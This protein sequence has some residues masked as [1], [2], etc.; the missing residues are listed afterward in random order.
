MPSFYTK[1]R[2]TAG[3]ISPP[4]KHKKLGIYQAARRI[5]YAHKH[6]VKQLTGRHNYTATRSVKHPYCFRRHIYAP[7]SVFFGCL[8][9][10]ARHLDISQIQ[11]N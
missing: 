6:G 9:G 11:V 5:F 3:L 2:S 7:V 10:I 4:Y 1:H 8:V